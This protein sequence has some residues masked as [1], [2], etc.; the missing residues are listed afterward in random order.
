M[1]TANGG[2]LFL[3]E[4]SELPPDFQVKMLRAL[5][6]R[7]ITPVGSSQSLSLD[8]RIVAATQKNLD[9]MC[10]QGR[11]REDLLYRL[12][13][14]EIA[15]PSLKERRADIPGLSKTILARLAKRAKRPVLSLSEPVVEKFLLYGWPGNIR[16]LENCLEHAATLSWADE[17]KSIEVKAL[18]ESVQFA[19]MSNSKDQQLKDAVRLFEKEYI[20][21]T[22]RR[23]GSKEHAAEALGLSL[24]TL[25]RKLG[26]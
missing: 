24:A 22:I 1:A 6:E 17:K 4:V 7:Q 23:L 15:L 8:I 10:T 9:E 25:Y 19:T 11:F 3:D 5:Q 21:S 14:M 26:S 20:A 2:T 16:E 13:V 12:R 18:P